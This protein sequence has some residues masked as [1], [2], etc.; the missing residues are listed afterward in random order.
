MVGR[1]GHTEEIA[2]VVCMIASPA[3][4]FMTGANIRVNGGKLPCVN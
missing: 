1:F 3:A 4:S 2:H